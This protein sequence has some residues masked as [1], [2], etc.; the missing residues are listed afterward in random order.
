[1]S[2]LSFSIHAVSETPARTLVK[3]RQFE[4]IVDEPPQLGGSDLG[5]NPVEY[6]LTGLAGCLNVV[7]HLIAGELGIT[8]RSLEIKVSGPIN[9]ARLF[10]NPTE[11]RSGYKH[12][13]VEILADTDADEKALQH[14]LEVV[15][16]RC[17]VFDNLSRVTPVTTRIASLTALQAA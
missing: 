13:D 6:I 4:V 10:G 17:P 5:A 7:A 3:A 12:I 9:P 15:E 1:M 14:W 11:D 2:D 16:S 8:I